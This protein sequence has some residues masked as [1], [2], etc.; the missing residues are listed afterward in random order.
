MVESVPCTEDTKHPWPPATR[1]Q[2][3]PQYDN[4]ECLQTWPNAHG[5]QTAPL[6]S[7]ELESM[8]SWL[9]VHRLHNFHGGADPDFG[10]QG[11]FQNHRFPGSPDQE[12]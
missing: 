11:V 8:G 5:G 3:T 2:G 1:G 6:R 4:Q 12:L 7:A 10:R 9:T